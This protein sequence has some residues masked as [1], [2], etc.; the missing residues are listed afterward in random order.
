MF[1]ISL[2]GLPAITQW[3][4]GNDFVTTLPPPT[5]VLGPKT[6]PGRIKLFMP[7]HV[8]SAIIT[9]FPFKCFSGFV[10]S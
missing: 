3:P 4:S 5:T 8:L 9:F 10:R 6:T 7:I 2:A 1:L